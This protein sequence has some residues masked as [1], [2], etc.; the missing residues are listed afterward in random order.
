MV[1]FVDDENDFGGSNLILKITI[2]VEKML[3]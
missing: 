2:R 3:R 1:V